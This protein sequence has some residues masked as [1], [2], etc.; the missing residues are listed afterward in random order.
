M[1]RRIFLCLCALL[2]SS[3]ALRAQ[4]TGT[5]HGS[6]TD[7]STAAAKVA[8]TRIVR[9]CMLR[10]PLPI[11]RSSQRAGAEPNALGCSFVGQPA[12]RFPRPSFLP[13]AH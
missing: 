11:D 6:V 7:A 13:L 10:S 2:L 12:P 8:A 9:S 5:I 3:L 4:G 1:T